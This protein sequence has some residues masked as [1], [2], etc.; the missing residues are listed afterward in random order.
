MIGTAV[1]VHTSGKVSSGFQGL[2]ILK[3]ER[4]RSY[5]SEGVNYFLHLFPMG[6]LFGV[7]CPSSG[8]QQGIIRERTNNLCCPRV[9]VRVRAGMEEDIG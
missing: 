6:S 7:S 9:G 4:F 1:C 3:F 8:Y 5:L 2:P